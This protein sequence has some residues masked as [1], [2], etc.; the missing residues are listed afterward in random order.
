MHTTDAD[1]RGDEVIRGLFA[2]WVRQREIADADPRDDVGV[3]ELIAIELQIFD[4]PCG[5]AG[6]AIKLYL[7]AYNELT[8]D[9][10]GK[11][12]A[13]TEPGIDAYGEG[14]ALRLDYCAFR[15]LF[16]D[17]IRHVPELAPLVADVVNAP[18]TR[19]G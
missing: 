3:D 15:G 5:A 2:A 17:A 9:P 8:A 16:R 6:D 14:G 1:Q 10:A 7:L 19:E 11:L 18:L 12:Y 13:P 4:T